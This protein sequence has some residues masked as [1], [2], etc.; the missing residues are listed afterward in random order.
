MSR[1]QRKTSLGLTAFIRI[2]LA[3]LINLV[4]MNPIF[5]DNDFQQNPA[6]MI[7]NSQM[8]SLR[9]LRSPIDQSELKDMPYL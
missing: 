9:S 2:G 1:I 3:I 8:D 6:E 5:Y 4:I 7:D